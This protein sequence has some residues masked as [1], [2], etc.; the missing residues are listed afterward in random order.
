MT[1]ERWRQIEDLY[2]LACDRGDGVLAD[3]DPELR[4]EVQ[5]M[6]AQKSGG[7]VLDQAAFDLMMDSTQTQVIAGSRLGP[8][9]IEALLGQGGMGQVFRA[10]DTRLGREVAIKVSQERFSDRFEREAR[11]IAALNHPNICTLH[12]VGPNYLVMELVEG[13]T[14]AARLKRGKLAIE[15]TIQYGA[16]IASALSAAHAKGI[17]HRD[18]KPGNVMVTKVGVKVLD[19]G[20]AKSAQ[21][22]TLT[23]A[24]AVMGTP[25]Y[26]A[27]EQREGKVCDARTDIYAL[28]LVLFEMASGKRAQP[29][30]R[31]QLD[32][33][34]EKLAHIVEACLARDPE[35][36][37]QS[38][39]DVKLELE[40]IRDAAAEPSESGRAALAAGWRRALPWALFG[41]TVLLFALFAWVRGTGMGNRVQAEPVR[42][43]IAL[44]MKPPLQLT[45]A[46]ALSPDGRQL[47]FV[48]S[49][50][51]GIPRIYLRAMDSLAMRPLPGT[52]SVGVLLFWKPDGRFIAFDAGGKLQ[53]IDISGGP[54]ETVCSLNLTGVGGTWNAD[55]DILFGQFGGPIMRVSAAGGVATP[56]T[57]LDKS[58][59]EVAHT[60]PWFLPDGKHFLYMRDLST[61]GAI[62]AGSLDAKPE[63][64]DSKRLIQVWLAG[65]YVPSSDP[66]FG[67]LLFLRGQTLMA[68]PFDAAHLKASGDP[69]RVVEEPLAQYGDTGAFSVS[70][71]GTL[72]YWSSGNV[73]SRLT[74]FDAQGKVQGTVGTPG[75]Y[76]DVSLSPD[77]TRAIVSRVMDQTGQAL[78][79]LDM[80]RGTS[81]RLELDPLTN[82]Q[83]AVWSPDG[84]SI[85]FGSAVTGQIGDIYVK[86]MGGV[87]DA[88]ELIRSNEMKY[89]L[90]WSPDGRF[91]LYVSIGGKRLTKLWVLPLQGDR[92]PVPFL[93]AEFAQREGRFS[94]DGRWVAYVSN[95]SG[96]YEIYVRPFSPD[97]LGGTSNAGGKWL[98]S[99]N[100]GTSPIWRQDGKELYY[101]AP[102][103]KLMAVTVS[104]GSSF[105]AGIPKVL[106]QAPPSGGPGQVFPPKLAASPDGKRFL[107]L[108]PEKQEA[109]P[110]TV[111][112]NWQAGL[113]K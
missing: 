84:G 111:V 108:V 92:K 56:V 29:D 72:V 69:V 58:H 76:T 98:I 49:G 13:D 68:Q 86:R 37:L 32:S 61:D 47:A 60:E 21:D 42:L 23:V 44:P 70:A 96:R 73:E 83:Q 57:V 75:P 1:P 112:L 107:F 55:G 100:G 41:A 35:D 5:E 90:S 25:A 109:A 18:L 52:E 14:L 30:G 62:S 24:N 103:G 31:P 7:K 64:Q 15:A 59:G 6:L 12:D 33:L 101:I 79:L 2:N 8:Y 87:P 104:A 26:M 54:A 27:P 106:F 94:P 110:L 91:L 78:W 105:Q 85:I 67:Q 74:W 80:T 65:A 36:R 22:E 77:G 51:D 17:V 71:N 48:A 39:Q 102:D 95:E 53:K 11:A 89:P 28:G 38:A 40:W 43:Q 66:A 93:R 10:I 63:A 9:R 45:G 4:R 50:A 97:L 19:F 82:G 3:A 99:E 34:P 113:K 81:T 20:L 16:Q 46:L 88:E